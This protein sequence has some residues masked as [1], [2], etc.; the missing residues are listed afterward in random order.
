MDE[1]IIIDMHTTQVTQTLNLLGTKTKI[2]FNIGC[3]HLRPSMAIILS[4]C[5]V[6]NIVLKQSRTE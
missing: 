1:A 4:I 2:I 6:T 5:F 3:D